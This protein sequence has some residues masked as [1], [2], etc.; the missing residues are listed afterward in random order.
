[1]TLL[2]LFFFGFTKDLLLHT[3]PS[4][5]LCCLQIPDDDFEMN[6]EEQ[7]RRR[8]ERQEKLAAKKQQRLLQ[9][10]SIA[11]GCLVS[12]V[13]CNVPLAYSNL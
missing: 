7:E 2:K 11:A 5:P 1:M 12:H 6:D 10:V 13:P 4:P 8:L 3:V 9:H